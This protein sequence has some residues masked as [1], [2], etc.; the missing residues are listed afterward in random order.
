MYGSW[1]TP[2]QKAVEKQLV[3]AKLAKVI[4]TLYIMIL[5]KCLYITVK[6]GSFFFVVLSGEQ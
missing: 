2:D 6:M 4:C 3:L 1:R 5:D